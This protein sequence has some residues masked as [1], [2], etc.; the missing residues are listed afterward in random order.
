MPLGRRMRILFEHFELE[1]QLDYLSVGNGDNSQ[2]RPL[3]FKH[4]GRTGPGNLTSSGNVVWVK[5]VSSL[6]IAR[7]GFVITFED[8]P[9]T[10]CGVEDVS[11]KT[12]PRG[13]TITVATPDYPKDYKNYLNCVYRFQAETD[14]RILVRLLDFSSELGYDNLGVGNGFDVLQES[15]LLWDHSGEGLPETAEFLSDGPVA[16]ISFNAD[17]VGTARGFLAEIYDIP[18]DR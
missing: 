15:S 13:A 3:L 7:S 8:L 16:W 5:F 18:A 12:L 9:Y 6:A 11:I 14:R 10:D 1:D 4:S 17:M 2:I